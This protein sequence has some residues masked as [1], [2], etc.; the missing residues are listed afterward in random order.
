MWKSK[1]VKIQRT[2][3]NWSRILKLQKQI[4]T[5]KWGIMYM[6]CLKK[7]VAYYTRKHIDFLN[8]NFLMIWNYCHF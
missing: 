6:T 4:I 2:F 1:T 8:Q 5:Y 7:V 3:Q